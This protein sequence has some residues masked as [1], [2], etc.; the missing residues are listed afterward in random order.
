[1]VNDDI[2][3]VLCKEI[4]QKYTSNRVIVTNTFL[5]QKVC[6]NLQDY[7]TELAVFNGTLN[8]WFASLGNRALTTS[9]TL[10]NLVERHAKFNNLDSWWFTQRPTDINFS[11]KREF[12]YAE[13]NDL[14]VTKQGVDYKTLFSQALF[15]VNGYLHRSS[16]SDD[17][18]YLIDAI[19]TAKVPNDTHSGVL[20]FGNISTLTCYPI[21]EDQ[22][23]PADEYSSYNEK[24]MMR[25]PFNAKGK[26]VALVIG[27]VLYWQCNALDII[28]EQLASINTLHINWVDRYFYDRNW[29]NLSSIPVTIDPDTPDV[30]YKSE[31]QAEAFY[32]GWLGLSQSF[33]V[34]FD[35]PY[36]EIKTIPLTKYNWP[37]Q[38]MI[39]G[40][41]PIPVYLHNGVL[42]EPLLLPSDGQSQLMVRHHKQRNA[43]IT[44]T[45]YKNE[46]MVIDKA[47]MSE[48]WVVP[49]AS[50]LKISTY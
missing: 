21:T 1:M 40:D 14:L 2:S 23:V 10:P 29:L 43:L 30:L 27:G 35:N 46:P 13:A 32:K 20:T 37:G 38:Y 3:M 34:V 31:Y 22:Y 8:D 5:P 28:G 42:A 9:D 44:T 47:L 39:T 6:L 41:E 50:W 24:I 18:I 15:T 16:L 26:Q 45:S 49:C 17:G 11:P 12:T 36:L 19:R 25:L 4:L 7:Y 48:P 33:W